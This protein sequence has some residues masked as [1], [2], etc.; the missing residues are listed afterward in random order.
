[1][2]NYPACRELIETVEQKL[3]CIN[4]LA[5]VGAVPVHVLI[6]SHLRVKSPLIC[7]KPMLQLYVTTVLKSY[8][9]RSGCLE[10]SATT[11]AAQVIPRRTK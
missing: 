7:S 9:S 3:E 4:L 11:T 5:Q 1:M 6:A 8:T 2:K 10:E